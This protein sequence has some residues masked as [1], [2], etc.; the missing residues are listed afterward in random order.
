MRLL[1]ALAGTCASVLVY[2]WGMG[3]SSP[4][5]DSYYLLRA[6]GWLERRITQL[7]ALVMRMKVR[8]IDR[9]ELDRVAWQRLRARYV[10][11]MS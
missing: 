5:N 9:L 11:D 8:L 3:I 1:I 2:R 7:D 10:P 6:V 4:Q